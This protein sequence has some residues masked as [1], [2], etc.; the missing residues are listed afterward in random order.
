MLAGCPPKGPSYGTTKPCCQ[1]IDLDI[2]EERGPIPCRHWWFKG[3]GSSCSHLTELGKFGTFHLTRLFFFWWFSHQMILTQASHFPFKQASH[4]QLDIISRKFPRCCDEHQ[5]CGVS[6]ELI[7]VSYRWD[8]GKRSDFFR[9]IFR[10]FK[11]N[12][13]K[14]TLIFEGSKPWQVW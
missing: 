4:L 13:M 10:R 8:F 7:L 1:L 2:S 6:F 14:K 9:T 12:D 5:G 11:K 3:L